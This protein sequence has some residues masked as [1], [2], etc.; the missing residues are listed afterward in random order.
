MV[1]V[2]PTSPLLYF[3]IGVEKCTFCPEDLLFATVICPRHVCR[4]K[5]TILLPSP[6]FKQA[7]SYIIFRLQVWECCMLNMHRPQRI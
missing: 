3:Y 2:V 1:T 5:L 7:S 4:C 6:N